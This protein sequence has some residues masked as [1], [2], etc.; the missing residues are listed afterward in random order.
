MDIPIIPIRQTAFA[1]WRTLFANPGAYLRLSWLPFVV[2]LAANA[3]MATT[4]FGGAP[5]GPAASFSE[6][7]R[8]LLGIFAEW[9]VWLL[10]V[11]VATA[12]S[13]H[14]EGRERPT[15]AFGR[16][17]R[18]Y[19]WRYLALILLLFCTA[20]I[21]SRLSFGLGQELRAMIGFFPHFMARAA[22]YPVFLAGLAVAFRFALILPAAAVGRPLRLG[23]SWNLVRANELA[24]A[25]V[26]I[27]ASLP[28]IPVQF[29]LALAADGVTASGHAG[30]L[31]IALRKTFALWLIWPVW[32]AALALM[33]ARL[34]SAAVAARIPVAGEPAPN[35]A[36]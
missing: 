7:L 9:A 19:L 33:H 13:R 31:A 36:Q 2:I 5:T 26:L 4:G 35:P 34:T 17:E 8:Q 20:A 25:G 14:A 27:L 29:V 3:A 15:L 32:A 18:D 22:T 21:P 16:T 23:E 11:P 10:M 6:F 12:W 24:V 30:A 28:V 1:A